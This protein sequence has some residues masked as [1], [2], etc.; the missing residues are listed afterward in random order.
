[1]P[2]VTFNVT[3]FPQYKYLILDVQNK[4]C[5]DFNNITKIGTKIL[6]YL[7]LYLYLTSHTYFDTNFNQ[8]IAAISFLDIIYVQLIIMGSDK[9]MTGK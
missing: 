3:Y 8:K 2:T 6:I 4:F 5:D 7:I 1:M 9:K